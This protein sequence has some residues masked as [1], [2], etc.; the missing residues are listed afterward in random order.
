MS[1][2]F[3]VAFQMFLCGLDLP[4]VIGDPRSLASKWLEI[5]FSLLYSVTEISYPPNKLEPVVLCQVCL[6]LFDISLCLFC[7]SGVIAN[8]MTFV[9]MTK[10]FPSYVRVPCT[11]LT[12]IYNFRS[13]KNVLEPRYNEGQ[14]N[15]QNKRSLCRGFVV[16][17]IVFIIL[18]S[19]NKWGKT[20]ILPYV[21][22]LQHYYL[23]F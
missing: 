8:S 4:P 19:S 23:N 12:T 1:V 17:R 14:R 15:K 2:Q 16:S 22:Q 18:L 9:K 13:R 3:S 11:E 20:Y 5:Y 10:L 6:A 21:T 7:S